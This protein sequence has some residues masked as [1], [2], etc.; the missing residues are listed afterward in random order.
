MWDKLYVVAP[1]GTRW[2]LDLDTAEANLRRDYP[3]VVTSRHTTGSSQQEYLGFDLPIDGPP[4]HGIYVDGGILTLSDG[5]PADWA[6]V[7]AWWLAQLSRGTVAVAMTEHNTQPA[8]VPANA[9][10]QQ[11]RELLD[12]L[13]AVS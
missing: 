2:P 1:E 6:G 9:T 8:A 7:I 10:A 4:R 3:E 13:V 11:I 5:T 12:R